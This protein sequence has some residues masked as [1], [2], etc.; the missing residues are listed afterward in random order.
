MP[1]FALLVPSLESFKPC[2]VA[3]LKVDID[4]YPHSTIGR[5]ISISPALIGTTLSG[6]IAA[7]TI[8]ALKLFLEHEQKVGSDHA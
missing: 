2:A 7:A 8:K 1:L 3:H 6:I 4:R 5:R